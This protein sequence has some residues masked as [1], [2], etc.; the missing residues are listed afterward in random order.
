MGETEHFNYLI[1]PSVLPFCPFDTKINLFYFT[2]TEVMRGETGCDKLP[3]ITFHEISHFIF[4]R[5]LKSIDHKLSDRGIHHLKEVLTPVLLQHPDIIKYRH[6]DYVCGNNESIK[7]QVEVG[8]KV[9]SIFDYVNSEFLK[10]PTPEGYLPFL[11]WLINL[12][13]RIESEVLVRDELFSNNGRAVF[14]DPAL[15]ARFMEPILLG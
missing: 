6:Q 4:F 2:I 5:Q 14:T 8:G 1:M 15:K 10:N 7:Y 9:M 13:E 3:S 12:F 11:H